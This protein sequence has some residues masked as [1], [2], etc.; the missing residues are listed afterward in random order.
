MATPQQEAEATY[1]RDHWDI[2]AKGTNYLLLGHGAIL[3]GCLTI[4]KDTTGNGIQGLGSVGAIAALGLLLAALAYG[5]LMVCRSV[6]VKNARGSSYTEIGPIVS[7]FKFF[8]LTSFAV[9]LLEMCIIA[10][11]F[12]FSQ[13]EQASAF[14]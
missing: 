14:R 3:A 9:F 8:Q 2:Q 6:K 10:F 1:V 4:F 11:R 13:F 12:A 5:A 7:W